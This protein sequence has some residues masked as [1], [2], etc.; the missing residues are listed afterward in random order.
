MRSVI[1]CAV[2]FFICGVGVSG[3]TKTT[4]TFRLFTNLFANYSKDIRPVERSSQSINVLYGMAIRQIIDMDERNQIITTNVWLRQGWSDANLKWNPDDYGGITKITIPSSEIW[5]PDIILYN[6]A[7][8]SFK[9]A[10]KTNA[11]VSFDGSVTW[12]APAIFRSSCKI[13]INYFPFDK[14]ECTLQFGSWAYTTEHL[15]LLNRSASGDTGSFLVNGEWRLEDFP[16]IRT[17]PKY[18]CCKYPFS[19]LDFVLIIRRRPLFYVINMLVPCILVSAL[20]LLTFYLPADTGEKFTL[21]ITILLSLT[22]FL[23]LAAETMPPTSE[24]VPLIAQY[25]ITTMVL[26]SGSTVLT[27]IVLYIHHRGT[28]VGRA[29]SWFRRFTLDY[30][31]KFM[32]MKECNTT[33]DVTD[34]IPQISF[35]NASGS[36]G[37]STGVV[38]AGRHSNEMPLELDVAN[39]PTSQ[40]S[41]CVQLDRRGRIRFIM[42]QIASYLRKVMETTEDGVVDDEIKGEWMRIAFVV[43]RFFMWLFGLSTAV[44]TCGVLLQV[45][46]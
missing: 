7:D 6:N 24:V 44:A 28:Y 15:N 34:K 19:I 12:L 21:C 22:V 43:D 9:G 38:E 41:T 29:P 3:E 36:S 10:M 35:E 32:C 1:F 30:L 26:V 4:D 40:S 16:V 17:L 8:S 33:D 13:N 11:A 27:A 46:E 14:Q 39:L 18:G 5:K 42:S 25:Y 2:S 37:S 31:A 20:T 23:L 45:K